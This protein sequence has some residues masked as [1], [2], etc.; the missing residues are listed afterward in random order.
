M[1]TL[2]PHWHWT[3]GAWNMG[4]SS[5]HMLVLYKRLVWKARK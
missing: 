5:H 4:S 1:A 2:A 3:D